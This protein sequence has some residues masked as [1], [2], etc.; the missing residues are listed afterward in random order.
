MAWHR[1]RGFREAT[2]G[3][4]VGLARKKT[5]G[6]GET[7][8]ESNLNPDSYLQQNPDLTGVV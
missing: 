2:V 5:E 6:R 1:D 3:A 8:H 7:G 4:A